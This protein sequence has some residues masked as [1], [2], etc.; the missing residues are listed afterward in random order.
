MGDA[1]P[2]TAINFKGNR[3]RRAV[4]AIA[5]SDFVDVGNGHHISQV[6]LSPE[7]LRE[8]D[9]DPVFHRC[10]EAHNAITATLHTIDGSQ[11]VVGVTHAV[12]RPDGGNPVPREP[13]PHAESVT[14]HHETPDMRQV[15][16]FHHVGIANDGTEHTAVFSNTDHKASEI[17][18]LMSQDGMENATQVRDAVIMQPTEG[19]HKGKFLYR[20]EPAVT[21]DG[22][23]P[24]MVAFS[25][26][27][28]KYAP[29]SHADG[30]Q[31]YSVD[32]RTKG[33]IDTMTGQVRPSH[34]HPL[35]VHPVPGARFLASPLPVPPCADYPERPDTRLPHCTLP[36]PPCA[37]S[38]LT[39]F[40]WVSSG[41]VCD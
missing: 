22:V 17:A 19:P 40:D 9:E 3:S 38:P 15:L 24:A 8:H 2:K 18:T 14:Y 26:N 7:E 1:K 32:A 4:Y 12:Q 37:D 30:H 13:H 33:V 21:E 25:N 10:A 6:V 31:Y 29:I 35:R 27:A 23:S 34:D 11:A 41:Q 36:G 28:G 5:P 39:M 16:A 20:K